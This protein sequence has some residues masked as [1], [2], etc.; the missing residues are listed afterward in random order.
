MADDDSD[1]CMLMQNAVHQVFASHNFQ[2]LPDGQELMDYL[3]RRGIYE[4]TKKYPAPDLV[5]LDINMPRKDGL[6]A[7]K[8]IREHPDL[9]GIPV[10]IY[11]TSDAQEYIDRCYKLGANSYITKPMSFDDLVKSVKCLAEYWFT[12]AD[13]P[14]P[15]RICGCLPCQDTPNEQCKI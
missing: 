12:V 15:K 13:L 10:L 14:L 11:T 9:R 8:E 1:D 2:C 4:D 6:A 5:F 7:L 3:L